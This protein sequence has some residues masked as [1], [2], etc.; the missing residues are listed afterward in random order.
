MAHSPKSVHH[1]LKDRPTL[2]LIDSEINAQRALLTQVRQL[3]PEDLASHCVA[4]RLRDQHL[5]LHADSPVWAT[6]LRYLA[7]GIMGPM[8]ADH[9]SLRGVKIKL[10]LTRPAPDPRRRVA[11][12]SDVAAAIIHDTAQDT[13]QPQL[14]DALRRLSRALKRQI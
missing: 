10:L 14:R 9:P 6:R 3:L 12:R 1:L 11:R 8:Q 7:P 5:V 2:K 13:K 4:A